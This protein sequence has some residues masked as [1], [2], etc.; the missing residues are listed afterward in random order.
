[1]GHKYVFSSQ[2]AIFGMQ[3][4]TIIIEINSM[5]ESQVQKSCKH[6]LVCM[7]VCLYVCVHVFLLSA[8]TLEGVCLLAFVVVLCLLLTLKYE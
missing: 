2:V 8:K 6:V 5:L 4:C 3:I 1:M 7:R